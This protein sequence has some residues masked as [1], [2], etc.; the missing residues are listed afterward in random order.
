MKGNKIYNSGSFNCLRQFTAT[1]RKRDIENPN[2]AGDLHL[3][4]RDN[5]W[6]TQCSYIQVSYY[7]PF[8][9]QVIKALR[10]V[11]H[12]CECYDIKGWEEKVSGS[13][14]Q[15]W[16]AFVLDKVL[17]FVFSWGTSSCLLYRYVSFRHSGRIDKIKDYSNE[18]FKLWKMRKSSIKQISGFLFYFYMRI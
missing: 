17:S 12:Y 7:I 9:P 6:K 2:L 4:G 14:S 16:H 8:S 5:S 15:A 3:I 1:D 10:K 13:L 18:Y 11:A